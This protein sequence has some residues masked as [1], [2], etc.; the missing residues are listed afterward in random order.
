M[1]VTFLKFLR[2]KRIKRKFLY[3]AYFYLTDKKIKFFTPLNCAL[4]PLVFLSK[5]RLIAVK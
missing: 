3:Q 4:K 2:K 1:L 5:L